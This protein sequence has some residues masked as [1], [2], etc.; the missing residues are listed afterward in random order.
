MRI[1]TPVVLYK[2]DTMREVLQLFVD[3]FHGLH[4]F[5]ALTFGKRAKILEIMAWTRSF[6]LMLDLQCDELILQ[7]FNCFI[8]EIKKRHSDKV[9]SNMF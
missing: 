5:K 9:K 4:D 6:V 1:T 8:A 2:D 7:M 3:S